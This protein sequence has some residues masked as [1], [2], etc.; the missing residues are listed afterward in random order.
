MSQARQTILG[1]LSSTQ[2]K[3]GAIK[4]ALYTVVL[5]FMFAG[6]TGRIH[7]IVG[8]ALAILFASLLLM[9]EGVSYA[10]VLNSVKNS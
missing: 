1:D 10:T 6:M 3:D 2:L 7:L 5:G 8:S 4:V 9:L